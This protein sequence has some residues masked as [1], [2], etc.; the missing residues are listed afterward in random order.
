MRILKMPKMSLEFVSALVRDGCQFHHPP[1]YLVSP[2]LLVTSEHMASE[3]FSTSWP[4]LSPSVLGDP[5]VSRGV[6][7]ESGCEPG[8]GDPSAMDA[9]LLLTPAGEFVLL[10]GVSLDVAEAFSARRFS[11]VPRSVLPASSSVN[12]PDMRRRD[13]MRPRRFS[14][15]SMYFALDQ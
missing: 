5:M 8:L 2:M 10:I 1:I 4:V 13:S 9:V 15:P 6:L 7:F 11:K 12:R 14:K 3:R